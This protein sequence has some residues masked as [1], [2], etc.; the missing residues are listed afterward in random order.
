M[1]HQFYC[2]VLCESV[3]FYW[4]PTGSALL[5]PILTSLL[6]LQMDPG[7]CPAIGL[8]S[9]VECPQSFFFLPPLSSFSGKVLSF[10]QL[11]GGVTVAPT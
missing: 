7:R 5:S 3:I 6:S 2:V 9:F 11:Y 4:P 8:W 1:S 10:L